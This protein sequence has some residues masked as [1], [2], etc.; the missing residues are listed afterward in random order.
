M[1]TIKSVIEFG[2]IKKR[3]NSHN[4]RVYQKDV[5]AGTLYMLETPKSPKNEMTTVMRLC[6]GLGFVETKTGFIELLTVMPPAMETRYNIDEIRKN[7]DHY[8]VYPIIDGTLISLYY[9]TIIPEGSLGNWHMNSAHSITLE[10][11]KPNG[12]D[13]TYSEFFLEICKEKFP[14]NQMAIFEELDTKK[15]YTCILQHSSLHPFSRKKEIIFVEAFDKNFRNVDAPEFEKI[16][17]QQKPID[18]TD[19]IFDDIGVNDQSIV[20]FATAGEKNLGYIFKAS[21]DQPTYIVRS[22]LFNTIRRNVYSPAINRL[23]NINSAEPVKYDKLLALALREYVFKGMHSGEVSIFP[24]IF[25][26][27]KKTYDKIVDNFTKALKNIKESVYDNSKTL[28]EFE[29]KLKPHTLHYSKESSISQNPN[30]FA[31]IYMAYSEFLFNSV[32]NLLDR[33]S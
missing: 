16:F 20:K 31:Y 26:R 33:S 25:P 11:V 2:D 3:F 14:E 1:E 6:N 15:I 30:D 22:K 27:L 5:P 18:F 28:T 8:I 32:S 21:D 23:M 13:K 7:R 24:I 19:D 4:V 10:G 9:A 29:N 12:Y 17:S